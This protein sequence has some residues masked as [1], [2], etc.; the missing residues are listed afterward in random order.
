MK[1]FTTQ[2][3]SL[4]SLYW[5]MGIQINNSH[6][7][8]SIIQKFLTN[9]IAANEIIIVMTPYC[10]TPQHLLHIKEWVNLKSLK[11]FGESKCPWYL[12][13]L[14]NYS[15]THYSI[16]RWCTSKWTLGHRRKKMGGGDYWHSPSK[17]EKNN[18]IYF[19]IGKVS[20]WHPCWMSSRWTRVF[21]R[22]VV[23]PSI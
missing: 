12:N 6:R 11:T 13:A 15:Q 10:P 8:M 16:A 4:W 17:F 18:L 14:W 21:R 5:K 23:Q 22:R 9:Q 2:K 3:S 1:H 19:I 20:N 7:D